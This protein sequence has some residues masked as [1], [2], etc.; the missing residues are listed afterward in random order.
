MTTQ[1]FSQAVTALL[2]KYPVPS[3][4]RRWEEAIGFGSGVNARA[5]FIRDWNDSVNIVWL[6]ED[7]TIRDVAWVPGSESQPEQ[8]MAVVT[9]VEDIVG[10]EVTEAPNVAHAL[11]P[12]VDG[13]LLIRAYLPSAP[14]GSL[15]WIA[16]DSVQEE[17]LRKFYQAVLDAYSA[18]R[19]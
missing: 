9:R 11:G 2:A 4:L 5:F 19:R 15:Y 6:G 18:P 16:A 7:G 10:F 1:D 8:S 12:P 14:S 17:Q 3:L 13:D